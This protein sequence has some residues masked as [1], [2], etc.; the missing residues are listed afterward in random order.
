MDF[1]VKEG[2]FQEGKKGQARRIFFEEVEGS[3]SG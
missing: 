1:I 3:M 2:R